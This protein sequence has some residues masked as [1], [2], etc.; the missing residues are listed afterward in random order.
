MNKMNYNEKSDSDSDSELDLGD[1]EEDDNIDGESS[2]LDQSIDLSSDSHQEDIDLVAIEEDL[3][4]TDVDISEEQLKK[5][6]K[7]AL[8]KYNLFTIEEEDFEEDDDFFEEC[9]SLKLISKSKLEDYYY[10]LS[11]TEIQN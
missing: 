7:I 5:E 9:P 1:S 10:L 6:R 3:S 4:N 8:N 11:K 2:I